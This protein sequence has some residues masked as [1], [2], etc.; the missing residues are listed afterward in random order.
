MHMV[1]RVDGVAMDIIK[2]YVD[3][4]LD[5]PVEEESREPRNGELAR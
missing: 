5:R 2:I 4:E 1:P 3:F